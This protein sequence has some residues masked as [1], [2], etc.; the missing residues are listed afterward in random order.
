MTAVNFYRRMLN[1]YVRSNKFAPEV[2]EA[3]METLGELI[4]SFAPFVDSSDAPFDESQLPKVHEYQ[5]NLPKVQKLLNTPGVNRSFVHNGLDTVLKM[6]GNSLKTSNDDG[7]KILLEI[8]N[9]CGAIADKV[10]G[11]TT[12]KE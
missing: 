1:G 4:A 11:A 9:L 10:V 2:V 5:S 12:I 6:A 3:E 8:C 7:D